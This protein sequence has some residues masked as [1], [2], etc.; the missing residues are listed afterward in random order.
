MH[1][2]VA[3]PEDRFSHD[4]PYSKLAPTDDF[5]D[6]KSSR[7]SCHNIFHNSYINRESYMSAH[8]SFGFIKLVGGKTQP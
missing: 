6:I 5:S 4:E 7:M 8:V 3:N 2:L 1:D